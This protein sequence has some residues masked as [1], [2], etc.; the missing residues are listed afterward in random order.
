MDRITSLREQIDACRPGSDDLTLPE[1]AD[2]VQ[3]AQQD[4][5]VAGELDRSQ[6]F[7]KA[8]ISALHDVPVPSDLCERLLAQAARGVV[9]QAIASP[10][11]ED[12]QATSEAAPPRKISR[13]MVIAL[14]SLAATL[15]AAVGIWQAIERQPRDVSQSDLSE[16]V[17]RWHAD[18][19][20]SAGWSPY[21]KTSAPHQALRAVPIRFRSYKTEYGAAVVY[22]LA[23]PTQPRA[24]LVAIETKD[25]FDVQELPFSTL[26]GTSRGLSVAAW[27]TGGVLYVLVVDGN[28]QR[29]NEFLQQPRTA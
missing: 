27:Q 18:D 19:S 1:L 20:L 25:R 5:A 16:A 11:P 7:D 6:R 9:E 26:S 24:Y 13:R 21:G 22:D 17:V 14:A 4:R 10:S 8:V 3:S 29:I 28:A 12:A 23:P 15:L 2:L